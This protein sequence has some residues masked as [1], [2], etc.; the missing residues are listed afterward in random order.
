M[1]FE[2]RYIYYHPWSSMIAL[3]DVWLWSILLVNDRDYNVDNHDG[4]VWSWLKTAQKITRQ[5]LGSETHLETMNDGK[6]SERLPRNRVKA[7]SSCFPIYSWLK[8]SFFRDVRLFDTPKS[9]R[10][11]L[12]S[13]YVSIADGDCSIPTLEVS[14]AGGSFVERRITMSN[15]VI[16]VQP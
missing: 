3:A 12:L 6:S 7:A 5:I 4:N 16:S 11:H 13:A 8:S 9:S 15:R 10:V 1:M 14:Q 2:A